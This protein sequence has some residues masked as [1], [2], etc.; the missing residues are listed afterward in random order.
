MGNRLSADTQT[1]EARA[2]SIVFPHVAGEAISV[3]VTASNVPRTGSQSASNR[4]QSQPSTSPSMATSNQSHSTTRPNT[5]APNQSQVGV[6]SSGA[7]GQR[8]RPAES[9]ASTPPM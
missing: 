7:S 3:S 9:V 2:A 1:A 6:G 8:S 5:T 4:S